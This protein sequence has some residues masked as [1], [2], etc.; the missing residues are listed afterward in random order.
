M[1]YR[2]L[3]AMSAVTLAGISAAQ[4]V[5]APVTTEEPKPS[6]SKTYL[7]LYADAISQKLSGK[8]TTQV[9]RAG[10]KFGNQDFHIYARNEQYDTTG[11]NLPFQYAARGTYAGL[12]YRIWFPGNKAYFT[13]S[14]A[15]GISGVNQKQNDIRAGF[16][17]YDE[18]SSEKWVSDVYGD[19]FYVD[20]SQDY[21]GSIRF[22][23]GYILNKDAT[24]RLWTYGIFQGFASGKGTNG[25]ENRIE[26]G[27]GLGYLIQ[28]R[29]SL[30]AELRYGYSF[31]GTINDKSYFNPTISISGF[32][33]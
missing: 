14:W 11:T 5:P 19:A 3:V 23:P 18:W 6:N 21:F 29:V 22:R 31:R 8:S 13:S 15:V 30:N 20:L 32:F 1:N 27:A 16:A 10:Y 33:N 28:G 26:T 2:T 9:L 24:G 17:G 7:E 4:S 25:T 12:G